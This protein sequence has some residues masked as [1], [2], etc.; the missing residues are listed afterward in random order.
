M[1]PTEYTI[2]RKVQQRIVNIC[3]HMFRPILAVVRKI[4]CTFEDGHDWSKQVEGVPYSMLC[5]MLVVMLQ[6]N[7]VCVHYVLRSELGTLL[8]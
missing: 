4:I 7:S 5:A 1:K 6:N 2:E 3:H 8:R